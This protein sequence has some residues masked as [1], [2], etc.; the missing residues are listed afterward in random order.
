M[1]KEVGGVRRCEEFSLRIVIVSPIR[2]YRDGLASVLSAHAGIGEVATCGQPVDGLR[3][4][5]RVVPHILL[6]DMSVVNSSA[7]ARLFAR[8]FPATKIVALALPETEQRV[9][10]CAEAGVVGYVP[11][12]GSIDD[13][14]AAIRR[15]S[16]G[17]T[18]CPPAIAAGLMRR[19]ATLANEKRLRRPRA[20]LTAREAEVADHIALGLSNRAIAARLG[21]EVCTVKNHV[22]NILDKLGATHRADISEQLGG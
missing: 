4:A 17:E 14:I 8:E 1:L 16:Q 5:R 20:R 10:A 22:H 2:L 21:I 15:A 13:L 12:E 3:L 9:V 11:R 18:L 19:V 6:L 7:T